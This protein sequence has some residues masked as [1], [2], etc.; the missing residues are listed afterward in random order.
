MFHSPKAEETQE[1]PGGKPQTRK[2]EEE[3]KIVPQGMKI[4]KGGEG[5][6]EPGSPGGEG[7]DR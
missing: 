5:E 7:G 3:M 1:D 6:F 4:E 2:R